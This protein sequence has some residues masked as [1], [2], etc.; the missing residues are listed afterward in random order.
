MPVGV[1]LRNMSSKEVSE[2]Q[3][4]ERV[5]GPLGTA[6]SDEMLAAILEQLQFV[7]KLIGGQYKP[8]PAPDPH[9]VPRPAQLYEHVR[10]QAARQA[11]LP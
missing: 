3:A 5:N 7:A 8:N 9:D 4:F 11:Q 10:R 6:Y 2:W 1:L